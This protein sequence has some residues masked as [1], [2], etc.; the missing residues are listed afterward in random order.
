MNGIKYSD[1]RQSKP[2]DEPPK[3]SALFHKAETVKESARPQSV[4]KAKV[5]KPIAAKPKA[6]DGSRERPQTPQAVRTP[7]RSNFLTGKI[8][9]IN[10]L[11]K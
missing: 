9:N 6:K 11:G 4:D 5:L 8:G 10:V 7:Q 3:L 1:N 2:S